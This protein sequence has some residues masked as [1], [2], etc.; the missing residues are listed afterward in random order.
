MKLLYFADHVQVVAEACGDRSSE[1]QQ[2]NLFDLD[3]KYADVLSEKEA[4][5][6]LKLGWKA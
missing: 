5:Q 4:V 1:I 2:A 6:R 3:S